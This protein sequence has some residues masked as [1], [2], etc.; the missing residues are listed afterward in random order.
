[1]TRK[2]LI[3]KILKIR[4]LA[5]KGVAGEMLAANEKL[6]ALM[7]KYGITEEELEENEET[8]LYIVDTEHQ[9]QLFVQVYYTYFDSNRPVRDIRKMK[10]A[11]RKWL[12]NHGHGDINA[13]IAIDCTK[14]EYV[15]IIYIFQSYLAD[16]KK[17]YA[18]FEYA[19]YSANKLLPKRTEET[20]GKEV[21]DETLLQA[22]H[23]SL[24]I[25]K[26]TVNKAIENQ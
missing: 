17:K 12:A 23:M 19:Y 25:E 26:H 6:F 13:T 1:M 22:A 21:D 15:Q 7:D 14:A 18:A 24:T 16:F 11:Y 5:E 3:N 10:K 2:D 8:D 20:T 9:D 4:E